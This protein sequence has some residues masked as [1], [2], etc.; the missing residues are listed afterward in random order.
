MFKVFFANN[1]PLSPNHP[2]SM[3]IIA[4]DLPFLGIHQ[5]HNGAPPYDSQSANA[6]TK[7]RFE[8]MRYKG[9]T[10]ETAIFHNIP[11]DNQ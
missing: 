8:C 10:S 11:E 9:D 7:Y 3:L 6:V 2:L 1:I 4:N 5:L